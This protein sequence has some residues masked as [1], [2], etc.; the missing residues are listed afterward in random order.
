MIDIEFRGI[1][2]ASKE[3]LELWGIPTK[4][5]FVYGSY[6]DGFILG[7]IVDSDIDYIDPEF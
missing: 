6:D 3:E 2:T 4:G 1:P 5:V 7:P